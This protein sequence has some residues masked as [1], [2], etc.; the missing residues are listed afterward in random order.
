MRLVWQS[1]IGMRYAEAFTE[2][3][4]A[5]FRIAGRMPGRL[6]NAYAGQG[7]VG[8]GLPSVECRQRWPRNDKSPACLKLQVVKITRNLRETLL[9]IS[10]KSGP[11]ACNEMPNGLQLPRHLRT[12]VSNAESYVTVI[13]AF[14]PNIKSKLATARG[15]VGVEKQRAM[16]KNECV[17]V[18]PAK[19]GLCH[20]AAYMTCIKSG[21]LLQATEST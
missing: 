5:I 14:L 12:L 15:K 3:R 13:W 16:I 10:C 18:V 8:A 6:L 2:D 20:C 4:R 17:E 7:E 19:A 1:C 11:P 21:D 9:R